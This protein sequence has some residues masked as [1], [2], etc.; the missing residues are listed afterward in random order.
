MFH[1]GQ[2]QQVGHGSGRVGIL[3]GPLEKKAWQLAGSPDL[4]HG[5]PGNGIARVIKMEIHVLDVLYSV[6]AC[7]PPDAIIISGEDINAKLGKI[8]LVES[9][10]VTSPHPHHKIT[11]PFSAHMH[12][13]DRGEKVAHILAMYDLTS[14][15]TWFEHQHYITHWPNYSREAN[16]IVHFFVSYKG[17]KT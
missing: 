16:Q 7:A 15:A 11:G 4:I 12:S 13:N 14:S 2:P 9:K 10:D 6:Y 3:L 1:N 5:D 8:V 17:Q